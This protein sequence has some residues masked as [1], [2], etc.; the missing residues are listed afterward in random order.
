[1]TRH[2]LRRCTVVIVPRAGFLLGLWLAGCAGEAVPGPPPEPPPPPREAA[3]RVVVVSDLNG[4]YGETTY[5]PP[6]HAAVERVLALAPDLVLSTGDM[7]AGQRG[8]LDYG[9]MWGGFHAAV[10]DPLEAA[11]IPFAIAPGNHDASGYPA[12]ARER[13]AYAEAWRERRPD[14]AIVDGAQFPF[15]YTFV[16]GP[17][18]FVALDATTIGPLDEAQMRWLD[19][20][21]GS[22]PRAVRIVFGHV[23]LY[24]F[25]VGRER[26]HVGDAA[27]EALLRRHEV[28]LF[29]SGHHHAYYPGRRGPLRLVSTACLGGGPRPLIGTAARSERA[30][31]AFEVTDE[32]VRALDGYGG[33]AFDRRLERAAL[34]L[35]VGEGAHAIV[36]DDS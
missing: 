35:V 15:R 28:A 22:A 4:E 5:A 7:V 11:A 34:P 17:A 31:L 23:P 26:E 18:F 16:A 9:A 13:A 32:G 21:L 14:V 20:A 3:L 10:S 33:D 1:M 8:G 25:T 2:G 36:R 19:A 30:I 29:V 12:Y 24:P 27:L 6:V